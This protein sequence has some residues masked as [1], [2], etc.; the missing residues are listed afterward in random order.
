VPLVGLVLLLI[1]PHTFSVTAICPYYDLYFSP[2]VGG[3]QN[4]VNLYPVGGS[5]GLKEAAQYL[6]AHCTNG[7]AVAVR[8]Y[9]VLLQYYEPGLIFARAPSSYQKLKDM[10]FAYIV[11][12]IDFIQEDSEPNL[13]GFQRSASRLCCRYSRDT[14]GLHLSGCMIVARKRMEIGSHLSEVSNSAAFPM[15]ESKL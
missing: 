10:G 7:T 4:A 15:W 12:Q 2:L 8:G 3:P 6:A 13:A 11:F 14:S 5:I 9:P 1:V